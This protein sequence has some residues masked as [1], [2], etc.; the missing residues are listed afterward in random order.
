MAALKILPLTDIAISPLLASLPKADLHIHQEEIPRLERILA[1]HEGRTSY[2]WR[3]WA[4]HLLANIPPGPQR[5]TEMFVPDTSFLFGDVTGDETEYIVAKIVDMLDEEA[6]DGAILAEIRFGI[7][8]QAMMRPDFMILFREAER[9]AQVKY[10]YLCAEAIAL[11]PVVHDTDFLRVAELRLETCL[12]FAKQGLAGIDFL[13]SPYA[14]E[15]DPALWTIVSRWAERAWDAGLGITL[16]AGEFSSAN[17]AA[18]IRVP[19]VQRIGHAVHAVSDPRLL[20]QLVSA[21]ITVECSL[22]CNVILGAVSTYE[23]H[24][25]RELM[26]SGVPV[27]LNTDD[28]VRVWTTIGREYAIAE[29]LNFTIA[30]LLGFT[31]NAIQA[32]FTSQQRQVQLMERVH[33]WQ[34]RETPRHRYQG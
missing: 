5:L 12:Q 11:F 21:G 1:R 23:A 31:R 22:S 13:M 27:T 25:I 3:T 28:P 8:G 19:H 18:A 14:T 6:E 9:Y 2:N 15:A 4:Q 7:G 16:H 20:E 34:V 30:E 29:T 26:T 24:P 17:L 32:S 33:E 10:P